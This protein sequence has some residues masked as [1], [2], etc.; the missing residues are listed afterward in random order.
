MNDLIFWYREVLSK[1]AEFSGRARR[2]EYWYFT[3]ANVLLVVGVL[4]IGGLAIALF[5]EDIGGVIFGLL[6]LLVILYSLAVAIPSIAVTVRRLHDTNR[7]GWW[8]LISLIPF[9][10]LV[11][12]YFLV[13]EGDYGPNDYGHDPKGHGDLDARVDEL[14]NDEGGY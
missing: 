2:S 9:G 4:V 13:I 14:Y 8:Y 1:Y 12:L 5:G 6:Y 7:S 3:L 10:S 11:L